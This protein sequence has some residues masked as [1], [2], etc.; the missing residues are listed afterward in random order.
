MVAEVI[1]KS[2]L[3]RS[4][5]IKQFIEEAGIHTIKY[6]NLAYNFLN[7][8]KDPKK[9]VLQTMEGIQIKDFPFRKREVEK[10]LVDLVDE[11]EKFIAAPMPNL[12]FTRDNFASVGEGINLN[13]MY[14]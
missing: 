4:Q 11:P 12:Y 13:H 1:G 7:D 2:E 10:T 6:Q 9:L 5:F 3:I 8:I 14:S